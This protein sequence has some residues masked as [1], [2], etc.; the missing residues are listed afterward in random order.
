[1]AMNVNELRRSMD[2]NFAIGNTMKVEGASGIGKSEISWQ[3]AVEQRAKLGRYGYFILN[4]QTANLANTIGFM[5]PQDRE[6]NG[7]KYKG[8]TYTYPE[9]FDEVTLGDPAMAYDRGLMVI[10]EWGQ[11]SGDVKRALATLVHG[12]KIGRHALNPGIDILV[13]SNRPE[14]RSGVTK[15]YDFLINRWNQQTLVSQKDPLLDHYVEIGVSE[16]T[17]AFLADNTDTVLHTK[18]PKDQ[19]PWCTPRSLARADKFLVNALSNGVKI[20]DPIL[21]QNF[22]G[23]IG[24]GATSQYMAYVR[25]RGTLPKLVD[26]LKDPLGTFV[27]DAPDARMLTAYTLAANVKKEWLDAIIKYISRF[28]QSFATAFIKAMLKR[29]PLMFHT[30]E[31]GAWMRNNVALLAAIQQVPA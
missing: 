21:T 3:Y 28:P 10:E 12:K 5:I 23:I 15:E 31:V 26:I 22:E 14:D 9:Y 17:L 19:G 8:S 1:M 20:T 2:L 30:K 6:W 16:V 13:L 18:A 27:P 29:D 4:A 25:L 11:A 7:A 24:V